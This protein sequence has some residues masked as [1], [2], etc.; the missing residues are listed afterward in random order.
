M[1]QF[2]DGEA[3][4]IG[5]LDQWVGVRVDPHEMSGYPCLMALTSRRTVLFS[6]SQA[7]VENQH[8][9]VEAFPAIIQRATGYSERW[10]FAEQSVDAADGT[11]AWRYEV[12]GVPEIDLVADHIIHEL[13]DAVLIGEEHTVT[14]DAFTFGSMRRD[15]PART[16]QADAQGSAQLTPGDDR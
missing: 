10:T 13:T 1:S 4:V 9:A 5:L 16:E 2:Q 15:R 14:S 7:L 12:Q 3:I 11:T 6:L 8:W